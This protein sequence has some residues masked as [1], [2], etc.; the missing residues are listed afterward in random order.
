MDDEMLEDGRWKMKEESADG[1]LGLCQKVNVTLD[2][3]RIEGKC[4]S[5]IIGRER[6]PTNEATEVRVCDSQT[7]Q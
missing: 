1:G 7:Q 5:S 3:K 6:R 4:Y 2:M